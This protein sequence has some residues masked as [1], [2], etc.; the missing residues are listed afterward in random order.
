MPAEELQTDHLRVHSG[1]DRRDLARLDGGD[2]QDALHLLRI[3]Q[4]PRKQRFRRNTR[5]VLGGRLCP[6]LGVVDLELFGGL[7]EDEVSAQKHLHEHIFFFRGAAAGTLVL[8]D[9]W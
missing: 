2:K 1:D 6:S 5:V 7:D 3:G 4:R 9:Y 8:A